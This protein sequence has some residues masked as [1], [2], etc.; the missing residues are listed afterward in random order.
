MSL[1]DEWAT[2][3]EWVASATPEQRS[4]REMISKICVDHNLMLIQDPVEIEKAVCS[5]LENNPKLVGDYL[6]GKQAVVNAIFGKCMAF[7]GK[8]KGDPEL[9]RPILE[10]KLKELPR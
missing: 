6:K 1:W 2:W 3:D 7:F 10:K 8:Y 9:I 5:V 4:T